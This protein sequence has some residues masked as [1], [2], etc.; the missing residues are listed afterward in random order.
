MEEGVLSTFFLSGTRTTSTLTPHVHM[1][2]GPYTREEE[3]GR[4]RRLR[5]AGN[6]HYHQTRTRAY[7][8][9]FFKKIPK[10]NTKTW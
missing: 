9:N 3:I 4:R 1:R 6:V 7:T 5:C 2:A 10:K 8:L